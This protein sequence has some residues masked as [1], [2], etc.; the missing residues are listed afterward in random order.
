M[1]FDPVIHQHANI[2]YAGGLVFRYISEPK[3]GLQIEMNYIQRGWRE[4]RGLLG[5]YERSMEVLEMP[6]LTHFYIGKQS[7][8]RLQ[9]TLGPY[10][11]YILS[12]TEKILVN[13]TSFYR[14]Y[15]GM[16][17]SQKVEM[18]FLGGISAALRTKAGIFEIQGNYSYCLT[19]LFKPGDEEFDF[20]ITRPQTIF[21]SLRYLVRIQ[22]PGKK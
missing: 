9:F 19:N 21:L 20:L 11:S 8:M 10:I 14:D 16:P 1:A 6:F 7:R 3:L 18:G 17:Y 15:Y 22:S 13:D 12:D 5:S 4:P 2:G